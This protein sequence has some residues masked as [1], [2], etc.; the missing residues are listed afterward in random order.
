ME[1]R[2]R[3]TE[4]EGRDM[5]K[6]RNDTEFRGPIQRPKSDSLEVQTKKKNEE[7]RRKVIIRREKTRKLP[8]TEDISLQIRRA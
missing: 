5:E 6:R 7:N 8:R 1:K 4:R 2:N 3:E